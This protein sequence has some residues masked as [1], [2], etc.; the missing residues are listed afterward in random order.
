MLAARTLIVESTTVTHRLLLGLAGIFAVAGPWFD[1]LISEPRLLTAIAEEGSELM[2]ATVLI[3]LLLSLLGWVPLAPTFVTRPLVVGTVVVTIVGAIA[4]IGVLSMREYVTPI[5]SATVERADIRHG[6]LSAIT[7]HV[8]INRSNLTRIDVWATASSGPADLWLRVGPPGQPPIRESRTNTADA[9]WLDGAVS[10]T[11]APIPDSE[12][13]T[14]EIAVGAL[15]GAPHVFLGL[16]SGDPLPDGV[17][18][19]DGQPVPWANDLALR[20]Y[21]KHRLPDRVRALVTDR[22]ANDVLVALQLGVISLWVV[23][24]VVWLAASPAAS[25]PWSARAVRPVR[26]SRPPRPVG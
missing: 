23:A 14:Y 20:A 8:T 12:G 25:W 24:V 13:Q 2:A 9:H 18:H 22:L 10:F 1:P 6:P 11:F 16:A 26:P 4:G 3:A 7:Q 17:A 5:T 21:A 15:P 19:V